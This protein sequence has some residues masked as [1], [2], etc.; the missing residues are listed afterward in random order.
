MLD[1]LTD[2][3][4]TLDPRGIVTMAVTMILATPAAL[5]LAARAFPEPPELDP[6]TIVTTP[7]PT[8]ST[9]P[10]TDARTLTRS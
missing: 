2:A 10:S 5:W 4:S 7:Q 9:L 3:L 1:Q 8:P 6:Q